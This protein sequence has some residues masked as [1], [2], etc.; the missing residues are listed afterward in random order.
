M[1]RE[2]NRPAARVFETAFG[3]AGIAWSRVGV[4]RFWL[5]VADRA[6]MAHL[7]S[8]HGAE[9]TPV[10]GTRVALIDRVRGYFAGSRIGFED[11][12]LDLA[13]VDTFRLAVYRQTLALSY[14]AT[15][16]Y[17]TLAR[18]AGHDGMAREVGQALG[19]NPLPLIVP[20][21]RILA[22]GNRIGGFSGPG[23]VAMKM[24]MLALEGVRPAESPE[25]MAL[26]L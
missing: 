15:T 20:C 26:P 3:W 11:L 14:G 10:E 4:Q 6:R 12:P 9:D 1:N 24:R 25:Q 5:P 2:D 23:G 22:S 21:H 19:A 16:T 13:G 17:G 18:Q 7:M 8:R